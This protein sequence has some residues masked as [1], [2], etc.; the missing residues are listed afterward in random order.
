[1]NSVLQRVHGRSTHLEILWHDILCAA[2]LP[3]PLLVEQL[4]LSR[5]PPRLGEK[6]ADKA[7]LSPL[8]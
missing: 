4:D 3:E 1:M 5:L 6:L 8:R 2:A 7:K